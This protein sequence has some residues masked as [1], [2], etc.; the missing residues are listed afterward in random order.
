MFMGQ[1]VMTM[2][3]VNGMVVDYMIAAVEIIICVHSGTSLYKDMPA[4]AEFCTV[5]A[6][7][8]ACFQ[9]L[10]FYI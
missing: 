5:S 4:Q 9:T 6:Q 8:N 7:E 10:K 2:N 3:A 1:M